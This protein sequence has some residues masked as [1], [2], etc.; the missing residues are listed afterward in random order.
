[1]N[2]WQN[3]ERLTAGLRT[4]ADKIRRLGAAG[5]ARQQIADFLGVRYQH[6][7]NVLVDAEK[8]RLAMER[9]GLAEP[10][11]ASPADE[12][13]SSGGIRVRLNGD[14]VIPAVVMARAG[15]RPG[16]PVA[17]HREEDGEIHLLSREEALRRAQALIRA[18][19]PEGISAVDELAKRRDPPAA[20]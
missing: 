5:Y 12:E 17:V 9:A 20:L 4:K 6:V 11:K 18:F 15:F 2:A 8:M 13:G 1:M 3:M 16:D 10:P 7:R 19:V 14:V